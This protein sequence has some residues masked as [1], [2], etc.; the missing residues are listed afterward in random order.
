LKLPLE[1]APPLEDFRRV[2]ALAVE[3]DLPC[4]DPTGAA[5][6]AQEVTASLLARQPGRLSGL[7]GAQL[8]LDEVAR[9]LQAGHAEASFRLDDGDPVAAGEVIGTVAGSAAT[10]FAAER[11]L[12]NIV[13]HLSGVATAT[14]AMVAA[15]AGAPGSRAVVRDTRKTLPGLRALQ[16]YAVRCGGGAN[17]R[18]SLSEAVLVKDN[19]IAALGGVRP[20][21]EA[22]LRS[23]GG[24]LPVEVEVDDLDQLDEALGAGAR[25]V[26]LDNMPLAEIGE[27]VRRAER[28]GAEVEASGGITLANAAAVAACGVHYIAV[29]SITHSAPALDVGLD[30]LG[31]STWRRPLSAPEA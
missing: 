3:E 4:G 21:V 16:K 31:P 30:L 9:H 28:A 1:L 29:G 18:M 2:A 6:G 27:A 8:V 14:A 24:R 15:V 19:H 25:L 10:V 23:S 17:H 22:A 13:S 11:A 5:V 26:L 20:A 7:V 12:L